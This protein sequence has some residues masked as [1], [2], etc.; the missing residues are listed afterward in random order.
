MDIKDIFKSSQLGGGFII[1]QNKE[2]YF[3]GFLDTGVLE[4]YHQ[5]DKMAYNIIEKSHEGRKK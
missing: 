2:G 1:F 4:I 3:I 5:I